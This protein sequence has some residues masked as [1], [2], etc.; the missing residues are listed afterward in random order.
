MTLKTYTHGAKL[1]IRRPT[2]DIETVINTQLARNGVIPA[3]I[4]A[5]M[6]AATKA[7]GRGDILSQ[8]PNVVEIS[9][10]DQRAE[11][12]GR[13]ADRAG[14]FPGSSA[15]RQAQ[16]LE[17]ELA[18][19]DAAHPEVVAEINARRAARTSD[20]AGKALRMED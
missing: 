11:I 13:L 16:A 5:K 1:T 17:A 8:E 18:A 14:A 7:A 10:A 12:A 9:L 15:W 4:F 19:F 2:G 20:A 3:D 6:V